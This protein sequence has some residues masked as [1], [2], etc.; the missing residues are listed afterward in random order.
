VDAAHD[1]ARTETLL[2]CVDQG[3]QGAWEL[4]LDEH[5]AYLRRVIELRMEDA[6]RVRVDPSDIVQETQIVATRRI[7][8]FLQRRPTS[9]RIW[10]RRKALERLI[11]ARRRHL[12]QKR[13]VNREVPLSNLS[14]VAVA[15]HLNAL[16]ATGML[17]QRELVGQVSQAMR[18]LKE[19]DVEVLLLRHGEQ[20]SNHE[21]AEVLEIDPAAASKRYGRAVRRLCDQLTKLGVTPN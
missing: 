20:L 8:D 5:R 14:S 1:T 16:S 12:A 9:F 19:T 15:Q 7:D 21:V 3:D 4:L 6:L 13:S 10:L 11:E 17:Q 2:S 18:L